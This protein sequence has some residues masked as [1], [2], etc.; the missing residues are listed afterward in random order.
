MGVEAVKY[1]KQDR[2]KLCKDATVSSFFDNTQTG[3]K[4]VVIQNWTVIF[5]IYNQLIHISL[6]VLYAVSSKWLLN[7]LASA[8]VQ[9]DNIQSIRWLFLKNCKILAI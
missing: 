2:K 4:L 7:T 8:T 1:R 3:V 9:K 6:E 5:V